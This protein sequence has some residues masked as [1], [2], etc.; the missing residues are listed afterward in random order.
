MSAGAAIEQLKLAFEKN[1]LYL[2]GG[3]QTIVDGLS[4]A[5]LRAGVSVET[6]A[7]VD[8]VGRDTKGAVRGVR[9]ADG[10]S[11]RARNVII[12]SSPAIARS[13]VEDAGQT[14]LARWAEE[15]IPVRAACLDIALKRLPNP[16]AT[17]A[18]G[19]DRPLYLSVHSAAARLAPEGGALIHVARYLRPDDADSPAAVERELEG[20]LDVVQPGWRAGLVYRRFLPDMIVMNDTAKASSQGTKGRPA[21]QVNDVQGLFVIGDWVG[22]EG[23]LVDASLASAKR[24]AEIVAARPAVSLRAAS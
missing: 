11:F 12:A 16:K 4:E 2:D 20:L 18:F 1:V 3:W 19:M 6:G 8:V 7:K 22:S 24:A 21:P 14:S 9:L 17:A 15:A 13:L 10:R 23:M 5:A